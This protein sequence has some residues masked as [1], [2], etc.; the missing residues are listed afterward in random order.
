MSDGAGILAILIF[1]YFL[2]ILVALLR[3]HRKLGGIFLLNLLAGWSGLG[4]V[5][6]FIWSFIDARAEP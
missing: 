4:W 5:A 1:G 6:A 2:P 3:G